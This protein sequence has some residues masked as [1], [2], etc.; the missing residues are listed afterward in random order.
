MSLMNRFSRSV[1]TYGLTPTLKKSAVLV[2]RSPVLLVVKGIEAAGFRRPR[3]GYQDERFPEDQ[4]ALIRQT[5]EYG[6]ARSSLEIGCNQGKLV[7]FFSADGLFAVGLDVEDHW[8]YGDNGNAILGVYPLGP[9]AV[10]KVPRF[11]L[12]C[13]LS[14]HHQWVSAGGDDQARELIAALF[15][16][17]DLAMFIEFAALADKYG[18]SPNSRFRDNDEPSVRRYAQEWL[19]ELGS[20]IEVSFLGKT[21][22]LPGKEPYRYL[23][24]LTRR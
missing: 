2:A 24:K 1:N 23:Y 11:D 21:R 15:E 3:K 6:S 13:L 9:A 18:Y 14:V 12:V 22:E 10:E 7:R 20:A 16:K 8:A 4:H 5:A 17:A 19:R